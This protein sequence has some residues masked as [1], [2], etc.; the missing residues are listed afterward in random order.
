MNNFLFHNPTR[1]G[2]E[3]IGEETIAEIERRFNER[4]AAYGEAQ[5]VTGAVARQILE[6]CR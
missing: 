5:N 1:L 4:K 6:H 2:E 3:N